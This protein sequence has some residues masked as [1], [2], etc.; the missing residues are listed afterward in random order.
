MIERVV[1]V[2]PA[3]NESALIGACLVAIHDAVA[4]ARRA[5]GN[6][7]LDIHTVAVLDSCRDGT[8]QQVKAHPH[9][10]I[11]SCRVGQ[12]GAAR[13]LGVRT[14]IGVASGPLDTVWIA[15]TDADSRVPVDWLTTMLDLA[16]HGAHLVLGTVQLDAPRRSAVYRRW[17][18]G[19]LSCDGHP[20]VHGANLGLRAD[21]YAELGGW[22]RRQSDE[23]VDLVRRAERNPEL[24]IRRTGAIPVITSARLTGRAPRGFASYLRRMASPTPEPVGMLAPV[25]VGYGLGDVPR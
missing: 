11:V 4:H 3:A 10:E 19:Y 23:D 7:R 25:K 15:N 8:E 24:Q 22:R 5:A 16:E 18:H 20:H 9:V 1:V 14:A 21:V 13:A 12:V 2:V 17:R 6:R